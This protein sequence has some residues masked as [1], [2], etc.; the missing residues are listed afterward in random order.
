MSRQ[1]QIRLQDRFYAIQPQP[2]EIPIGRLAQV[3]KAALMRT[4]RALEL[5][6]DRS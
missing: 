2:F 4:M 5:I 1:D 3:P 6:V